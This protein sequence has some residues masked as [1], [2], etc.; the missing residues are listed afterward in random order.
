MTDSSTPETAATAADGPADTT[1]PERNRRVTLARRPHGPVSADCFSQDEV[2]VPQ[3]GPG[4]ALVRVDWLSIDPTI[5]GWMERD[6]YLPAIAIGEPI[7]SG[8]LGVVV[9]S[10]NE[11]YPVGATIFG[12]TGWQDA[13]LIGDDAMGVQVLPEGVDATDALSVYGVTGITAYFGMTDIGRPVEGET[14]VV[15]GAAGAT[16]SVAAQIAK[17]RG[18]RVIGIAGGPA[19]CAWLTDTLG[20][21]GA[22]DYRNED[23]EARLAELCPDG[24]D[25]FYDNVGGDIL[26]AVLGRLADNNR[27]VLCGAIAQYQDAEPRPGPRNLPNLIATRG[28]MRG[29]I[30]LDHL[31]RFAEAVLTLAGWVAEGRIV[32]TVDVTEGLERAPEA[33]DRLFTGANTGKVVVKVR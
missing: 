4:Q 7:R 17:I 33:L 15:S 31:D 24:I 21:D 26:D 12:M 18:G 11:S 32:H 19:K 6:T 2:D 22:I 16:G 14:V 8:G 23:V 5:R 25:V 27:I 20:L 28:T 13:C 3:P 9:A 1:V 10:N 29:F 30:V